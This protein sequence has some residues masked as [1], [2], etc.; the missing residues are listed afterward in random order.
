MTHELDIQEEVLHILRCMEEHLSVLRKEV[1]D[2]K[3]AR[4]REIEEMRK[5][6]AEIRNER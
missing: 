2:V 6:R 4:E 3:E 5:I 1:E